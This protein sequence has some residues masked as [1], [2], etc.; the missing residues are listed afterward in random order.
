METLLTID[1]QIT[2]SSQVEWVN[3]KEETKTLTITYKPGK[4]YE[5]YKI[6]KRLVEDMLVSESIGKF[7]NREVKG[8]YEF[9]FIG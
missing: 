4:K 6:E 7:L 2:N 9:K 5:Y 3:Y 1:K 8:K